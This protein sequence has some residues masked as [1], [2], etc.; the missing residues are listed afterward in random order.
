[1]KSVLFVEDTPGCQQ[2]ISLALRAVGFA[3]TVVRDGAGALQYLEGCRPDLILMDMVM[4][5]TGGMEV[6]ARVRGERRWDTIP[7]IIFTASTDPVMRAKAEELGVQGFFIK[8][9]VSI[10]E[11]RAA[12]AKHAT[13]TTSAT[14]EEGVLCIGWARQEGN[15][16]DRQKPAR[17]GA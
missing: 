7:V 9:R 11:L 5:G 10:R 17:V 2:A 6:L 4:P 14:L 1:M 16:H 8:A 15:D 3:V 13:G 12:V